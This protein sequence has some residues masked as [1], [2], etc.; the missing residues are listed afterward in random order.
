LMPSG[1][2]FVMHLSFG[3]QMESGY[4][5]ST[6]RK[7]ARLAT[8]GIACRKKSM[9]ITRQHEATTIQELNNAEC[10]SLL[11]IGPGGDTDTM[12]GI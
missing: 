12:P 7:R 4:L 6:I 9:N 3:V 11:E 8:F 1:K 10:A 5:F 2:S